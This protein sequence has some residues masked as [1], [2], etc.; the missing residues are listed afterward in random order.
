MLGL[1]GLGLSQL[2][3]TNNPST[4]PR[5]EIPKENQKDLQDDFASIS[6]LVYGVRGSKESVVAAVND[7]GKNNSPVSLLRSDT[8]FA[9]PLSNSKQILYIAETNDYDMGKKL[10]VKNSRFYNYGKSGFKLAD[11]IAGIAR[12]TVFYNNIFYLQTGVSFLN[13]SNTNCRADS[14]KNQ[15]LSISDKWYKKAVK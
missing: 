2:N 14:G 8:K 15:F 7:S 11:K 13:E 12:Q 4:P 1:G 5:P 9:Y 3:K 10:V 6:T